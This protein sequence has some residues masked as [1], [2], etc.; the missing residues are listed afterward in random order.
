MDDA[1][2]VNE[3]VW[4]SLGRTTPC[5]RCPWRRTSMRGYLG[6]DNP[7]HFYW[8]S[9][10]AEGMMPCHE[11]I[12]YS[13]PEWVDTQLPNVD[14]CAGTLIY[15]RNHHK[16]P[17]RHVLARAVDAVKSSSA[18]FSRPTEFFRH[19]MPKAAEDEIE[20]AVYKA[21]LPYL[22]GYELWIK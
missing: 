17:R 6:A 5:A 14:L 1:N 10:T 4:P 2:E 18:V 21:T 20:E 19:H 22:D 11:Q 12:D 3:A 16:G 9:I 8:Q 15:F 7:V 13:D